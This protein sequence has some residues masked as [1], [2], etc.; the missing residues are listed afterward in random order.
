MQ[1]SKSRSERPVDVVRALESCFAEVVED[2]NASEPMRFIASGAFRVAHYKEYLRQVFHYTRENPQLLATA[3]GFLRGADRD[4]VGLFMRHSIEEVG[5]ERWALRDLAELGDDVTN[6]PFE[7]PLPATLALN[8]FAYYQITHRNPVAH[9]GYLYFLEFLP[10]SS[11]AVYMRL[12]SSIGVPESAMSFLQEH[13][14][15]DVKHNLLMQRYVRELIRTDDDLAAVQYA[16]RAT[17]RL[18]VEMLRA[19]FRRVETPEDWGIAG[20]E[21]SRSVDRAIA[22]RG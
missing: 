8:A 6:V 3:S 16:M 13:A 15:V 5:H 17:G 19:V 2:F 20:H 7:N 18:Y 21:L 12:L 22:R 10:T 4:M 1:Q 9:L 14:E 11:S